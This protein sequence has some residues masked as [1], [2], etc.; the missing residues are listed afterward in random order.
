MFESSTNRYSSSK[1]HREKM[2]V[3]SPKFGSPTSLAIPLAPDPS[4][5]NSLLAPGKT[6]ERSLYSLLAPCV[7][8]AGPPVV[9]SLVDASQPSKP[10]VTSTRAS[11][12]TSRLP[13]LGRQAWTRCADR[14]PG[15]CLRPHALHLADLPSL[16]SFRPDA[17]RS[18]LAST[19]RALSVQ[20]SRRGRDV[21][22]VSYKLVSVS[23]E[24]V[25]CCHGSSGADSPPS[26]VNSFS[27]NLRRAPCRTRIVSSH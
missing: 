15:P 9:S 21:Q 12:L 13:R 20:D 2:I 22:T 18:R 25:R 1:A 11:H 23:T 10:K 26:S 17:R 7:P 6:R 5:R 27:R 19:A 3:Q 8:A 4:S 24:R 16:P 14:I